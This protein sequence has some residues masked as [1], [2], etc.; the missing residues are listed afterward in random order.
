[1]VP[2]D[3]L[4]ELLDTGVQRMREAREQKKIDSG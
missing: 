1:M 2:R 4:K 3:A